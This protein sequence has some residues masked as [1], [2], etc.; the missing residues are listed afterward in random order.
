MAHRFL[1]SQ[2][3]PVLFITIVAKDRLAVFQTEKMKAALCVAINEARRS[4]GFLLF[5]YVVM[6]DHMHLLT[7]RPSTTSNV[8]RVLKGLT[9]HRVIDYLKANGYVSS[10]AKLQHQERNRN[11]KYSLW[12]TEKNVLPVFSEG[13]FMEKLN[14]IHQNPVRS[15]LVERAID[16]HWSSARIWKGQALEN[17][18]L[19]VDKDVIYWRQPGRQR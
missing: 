10:L 8:L 12:Q 14:Y 16:Y 3:S 2:D 4:A 15:D 18:P 19:L 11:Y 9:A 6:L 7:S 17:E 1:I 5:G 13:M